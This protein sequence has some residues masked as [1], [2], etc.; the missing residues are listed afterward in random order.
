MKW[1]TK[2]R[3]C[4]NKNCWGGSKLLVEFIKGDWPLTPCPSQEPFP[5]LPALGP[6]H[7]LLPAPTCHPQCLTHT[8]LLILPT[9]HPTMPGPAATCP[10]RYCIPVSFSVTMC[11]AARWLHCCMPVPG[12]MPLCVALGPMTPRALLSGFLLPFLTAGTAIS[13]DIRF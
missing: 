6:C 9:C 2:T 12:H 5:P 10:T 7:P 13:F 11:Y 1:G 4:W 8:Q 3:L